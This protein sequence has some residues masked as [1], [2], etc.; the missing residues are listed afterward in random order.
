[1]NP[2][3]RCSSERRSLSLRL[4]KCVT[5]SLIGL[6]CAVSCKDKTSS[7]EGFGPPSLLF[8][9]AQ[10]ADGAAFD[11][12]DEVVEVACDPRVTFRL[13]PSSD[14]EG[15]LDNWVL[16][17]AGA[18]RGQ[19][20]CGFVRLDLR[21]EHD[22]ILMTSDQASI[23]FVVDLSGQELA[24]VRAVTALLI[25]GNNGNLYL[26]EGAPVA[27]RWDVRLSSVDCESSH[28]GAGGD[29]GTGGKSGTGGASLGG[30]GGFGGLTGE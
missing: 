1:M 20:Q 18:C 27:D 28:G 12:E 4:K 14:L 6:G 21:D 9:G 2:A 26:R 15:V 19:L 8:L 22:E 11:V 29:S 10:N 16:R 17:P 24:E 5:F 23:N 25:N 3:P 30:A 7:E 13:G